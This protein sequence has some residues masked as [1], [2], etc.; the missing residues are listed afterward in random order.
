MNKL[1]KKFYNAMVKVDY[2]D[3]FYN[4]SIFDCLGMNQKK[5]Y[6]DNRLFIAFE[7]AMEKYL[8][9]N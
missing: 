2:A 7:N 3:T 4:Q 5:V 8:K 6:N 9:E 1:E